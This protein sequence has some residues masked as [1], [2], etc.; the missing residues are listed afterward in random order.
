[1]ILYHFT[2]LLHM[3]SI[4]QEGLT[5]G[6]VPTSRTEGRNGVWFTSSPLSAGHGVAQQSR[7]LSADEI[8]AMYAST[9]LRVKGIIGKCDVRITV[10]IPTTER[11]LVSWKR[12]GR[13]HCEPGFFDALN[14]LG[15]AWETWFIYF[16]TIE[17]SR[18]QSVDVLEEVAAR[19]VA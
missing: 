7:D 6:D 3:E 9:G 16:G 14:S 8:A 5:K 12:W 15:S 19:G 18:F 1:M 10:V 4:R 11:A 2:S 17:P 13:K